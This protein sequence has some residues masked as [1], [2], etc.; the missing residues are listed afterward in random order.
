MR[1]R[2]WYGDTPEN[3]ARMNRL[4]DGHLMRRRLAERDL[5]PGIDAAKP[6]EPKVQTEGESPSG[7]QPGC[8]DLLREAVEG[9]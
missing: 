9:M 2:R 7:D 3:T 1:R 6:S 5:A 8:P 4:I